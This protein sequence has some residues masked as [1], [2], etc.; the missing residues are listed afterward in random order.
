V[1]TSRAELDIR[2]RQWLGVRSSQ[3]GHSEASNRLQPGL[4]YVPSV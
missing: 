1:H 2:E 4:H 3:R